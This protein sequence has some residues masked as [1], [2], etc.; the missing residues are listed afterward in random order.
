MRDG[1]LDNYLCN[2]RCVFGPEVLVPE[3]GQ[4]SA[5]EG[6]PWAH[7]EPVPQLSPVDASCPSCTLLWILGQRHMFVYLF[8]LCSCSIFCSGDES[9]SVS[10]GVLS[11]SPR[12]KRAPLPHCLV[13]R[14]PRL[15][16]DV[17]ANRSLHVSHP[18]PDRPSAASR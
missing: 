6:L 1:S 15:P 2:C 16:R 3:D 10:L 4:P 9:L 11:G 5:G 7:L 12:R 17:C 8:S 18:L 14:P 13:K